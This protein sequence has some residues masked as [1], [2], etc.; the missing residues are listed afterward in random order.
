[1]A[2]VFFLAL[3][4]PFAVFDATKRGLIGKTGKQ[5]ATL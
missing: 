2:L 4:V 5:E 3:Y 1:V